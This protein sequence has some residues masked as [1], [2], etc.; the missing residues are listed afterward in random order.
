MLTQVTVIKNVDKAEVELKNLK[1]VDPQDTD[2]IGEKTTF[3]VS[4]NFE[5][6]PECGGWKHVKRDEPSDA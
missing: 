4:D 5:I 1:E 6:C 3:F 2:C